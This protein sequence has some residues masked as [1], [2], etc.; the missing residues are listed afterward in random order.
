MSGWASLSSSRAPRTA[1]TR[2]PAASTS[3]DGRTLALRFT[4]GLDQPPQV[5]RLA[6]MVMAVG[7]DAGDAHARGGSRRLPRLVQLAVERGGGDGRE[8]LL[9][10]LGGDPQIGE[11]DRAAGGAERAHLLRRVPVAM[12]IGIGGALEPLVPAVADPELLLPHERRD[13]A[14]LHAREVPH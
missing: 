4:T 12:V 11:L 3:S 14:V 10:P 2:W 8:V 13:L 7:Q 6:G 5:R 9:G 1:V